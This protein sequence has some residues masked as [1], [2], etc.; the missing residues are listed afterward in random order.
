MLFQ[1]MDTGAKTA[2]AWVNVGTHTAP[3]AV[4]FQFVDSNESIGSDGTNLFLTSGGTE[5][6]MPTSDAINRRNSNIEASR[7]KFSQP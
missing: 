6:K 4:E 3:P 5:F 2:V 7:N 1:S